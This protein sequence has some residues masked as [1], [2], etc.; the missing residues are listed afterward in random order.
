MNNH[1]K[2]HTLLDTVAVA[3]HMLGFTPRSSIVLLL[4]AGNNVAASLRLDA[5]PAMDPAQLAAHAAKYAGHARAVNADSTILISF[6]D[7]EAMTTAQYEEIGDQLAAAAMPIT[8]AVLVTGGMVMDYEGDSTDAEPLSGIETSTLGLELHMRQNHTAQL[9]QDV[10]AYTT[11]DAT[12]EAA[13]HAHAETARGFD[14]ED[15]AEH[16]AAIGTLRDVIDGHDATG[17]V[18]NNHAAWL[19]ASMAHGA[20]RDVLVASLSTSET[21]ETAIREALLGNT[22][23]ESWDY[24]RNGRRALYAALGAIPE[25]L[26]ADPLSVIAWTYWMDGQSSHAAAFC[27]LAQQA[28]PGHKLSEL[29]LRMLNRGHLPKAATMPH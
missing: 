21:T 6:E 11:P 10:P 14:P 5:A 23:P 15:A 29:M 9:A 16:A 12:H 22:T 8:T 24:L 25:Q 4:M 27:D 3:V 28:R 19:G 17:T 1:M 13:I 7:E 20:L 2:A 26:R 18:S